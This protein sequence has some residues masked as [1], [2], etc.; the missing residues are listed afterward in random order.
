MLQ[1]RIES[2]TRIVDVGG[3]RFD[4]SHDLDSGAFEGELETGSNPPDPL[5]IRRSR[6]MNQRVNI[7]V[8]GER[9]QVGTSLSQSLLSSFEIV[10]TVHRGVTF[11]SC[12][13]CCYH[14]CAK[15]MQ[16]K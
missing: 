3:G 10:R 2:N 7:N 6:L 4:A 5:V 1:Q 15:C 13:R 8:G 11:N 16:D 14:D 9:H 12:C